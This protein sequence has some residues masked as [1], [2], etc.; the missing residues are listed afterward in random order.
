MVLVLNLAGNC[1][2]GSAQELLHQLAADQDRMSVNGGAVLQDFGNNRPDAGIR[3]KKGCA[4]IEN[5][6]GQHGRTVDRDQECGIASAIE[7]V[8]QGDLDGAELATL[9]TGVEDGKRAVSIDRKSTR[10]NS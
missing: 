3:R 5:G 6:C 2:G 4:Q 1:G 9:G 10:L 8:A 7:H